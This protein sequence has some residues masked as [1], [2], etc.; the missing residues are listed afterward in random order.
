MLRANAYAD[1]AAPIISM[2]TSKPKTFTDLPREL[3]DQIYHEIAAV[4]GHI[5]LS[6][7]LESRG[8]PV[9]TPVPRDV[10]ALAKVSSQIRNEALQCFFSTNTFMIKHDQGIPFTWEG[11]K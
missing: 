4:R 10:L 5:E 9:R 11:L 7:A 8:F 6:C 1:R 3:R 2:A